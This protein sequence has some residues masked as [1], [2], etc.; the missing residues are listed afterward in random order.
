LGLVDRVTRRMRTAR[1]VGRTVTLRL[2]F[3]DFSRASRSHTLPAETADTHAVLVTVRHLM[4]EAEPMIEERGL[5]LI[6]LALTNLVS[7]DAEQLSL[8]WR[9]RPGADLDTAVDDVR[10]RFGSGSVVRAAQL[11]RR[12]GLSVPTLPD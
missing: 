2:R 4:A 12:P 8:P 6:G 9:G 7:G 10:D 5:T 1:R 11:G 3:D